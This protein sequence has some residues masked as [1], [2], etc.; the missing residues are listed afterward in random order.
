MVFLYQL[1]MF[2]ETLRL[3]LKIILLTIPGAIS[4]RPSS[5][6]WRTTFISQ[7]IEVIFGLFLA[8]LADWILIKIAVS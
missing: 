7:P 4:A 8:P 2:I 6:A 3:T 1:S 5:R